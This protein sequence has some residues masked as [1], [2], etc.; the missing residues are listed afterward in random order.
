MGDVLVCR[1]AHTHQGVSP[2]GDDSLVGGL[3]AARDFLV[4]GFSS[5][6]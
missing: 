5:M 2:S 1:W 6:A 4:R 3:E